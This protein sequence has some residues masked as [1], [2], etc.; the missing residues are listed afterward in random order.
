MVSSH[1]VV[2]NIFEGSLVVCNVF[3]YVWRIA[4]GRMALIKLSPKTIEGLEDLVGTFFSTVVSGV[5]WLTYLVHSDYMIRTV[6][7]FGVGV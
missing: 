2:D 4:V 1:F 5:A 7:D 6:Q 3:A